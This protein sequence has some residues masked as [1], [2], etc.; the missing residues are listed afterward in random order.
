M[1]L[2]KLLKSS[3]ALLLVVN[4]VLPGNSFAQ[5]VSLE[6]QVLNVS[7]PVEG[8]VSPA[9]LRGINMVPNEPLTIDFIIQKSDEKFSFS[10]HT[11]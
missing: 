11:R 10:K 3:I 6:P 9:L 4:L 8:A 5:M 1:L 7:A 2:N